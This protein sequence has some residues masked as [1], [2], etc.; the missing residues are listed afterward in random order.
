MKISETDLEP[1]ELFLLA[2]LVPF[3]GWCT[4]ELRCVFMVSPHHGE[5]GVWMRLCE[6]WDKLDYKAVQG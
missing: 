6:L 1:H 5:R 3:H 4:F 2:L